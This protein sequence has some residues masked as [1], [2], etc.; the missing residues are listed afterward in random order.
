MQIFLFGEILEERFRFTG[1]G[2][3][4]DGIGLPVQPGAGLGFQFS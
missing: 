1:S 2:L 3:G 4:S